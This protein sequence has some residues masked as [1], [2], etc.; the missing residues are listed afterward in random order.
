MDNDSEFDINEAKR[1]ASDATIELKNLNM[2]FFTPGANIPGSLKFY[3]EVFK[4]QL[5]EH[6]FDFEGLRRRF[7]LFTTLINLEPTI[8]FRECWKRAFSLERV[9]VWE[10]LRLGLQYLINCI[11]LKKEKDIP[12]LASKYLPFCITFNCS[13]KEGGCLFLISE[14][15]LELL[16]IL[17]SNNTLI[18]EFEDQI[19]DSLNLDDIH[20]PLLHLLDE[21]EGLSYSLDTKEFDP[22]ITLSTLFYILQ[23]PDLSKKLSSR[24]IESIIERCY[25]NPKS[26]LYHPT[27]H[28]KILIDDSINLQLKIATL[29]TKISKNFE[30]SEKLN[31]NIKLFMDLQMSNCARILIEQDIDHIIGPTWG[32]DR[33]NTIGR[34]TQSDIPTIIGALEFLIELLNSNYAKKF[35]EI[36]IRKMI[37]AGIDYLARA[38]QNGL[39]PIVSIDKIQEF[40]P[41]EE[42]EKYWDGIKEVDQRII[43]FPELFNVSFS[44]TVDSIIILLRAVHLLKSGGI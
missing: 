25:E 39:Q 10:H 29:L 44:N 1:L 37:C 21:N 24:K 43:N 36:E 7:E 28:G 22:Y 8:G 17:H 23:R 40:N 15:I 11:I 26:K 12:A 4:E 13:F 2:G 16:S 3:F 33:Y 34:C 42:R 27:N 18:R 14:D 41:K 6:T 32:R 20:L 5:K 31:N 19:L 38:R 30:F 35:N 9:K